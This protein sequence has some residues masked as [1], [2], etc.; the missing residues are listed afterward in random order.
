[1]AHSDR[2]GKLFIQRAFNLI[3]PTRALLQCKVKCSQVWG[4]LW[5]AIV[6]PFTSGNLCV[7]GK[8]ATSRCYEVTVILS[9][10]SDT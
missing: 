3:I 5:K 6:Q 8:G 4:Q 1:M 9:I 2:L 10:K 7:G